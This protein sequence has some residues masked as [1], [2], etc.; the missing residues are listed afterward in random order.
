M[1][2]RPAGVVA[3]AVAVL[4]QQGLSVAPAA[5]GAPIPKDPTTVGQAAS[6]GYKVNTPAP[7]GLLPRRGHAQDS[8]LDG[9]GLQADRIGADVLD[10][11]VT[12][13]PKLGVMPSLDV[14]S[15][16]KGLPLA[17]P[18]LGS[19]LPSQAD[20]EG[21]LARATGVVDSLAG[22]LR[23]VGQGIYAAN[24]A[25]RTAGTAPPDF[26]VSASAGPTLNPGNT[27]TFTLT[28]TPLN[29]E[30][31]PV[32]LSVVAGIT[33]IVPPS[34]VVLAPYGTT[35]FT[36]E[37]PG[38][39]GPGTYSATVEAA[40]DNG[41]VHSTSFS[42]TLTTTPA[43]F[44]LTASPNPI[45][46]PIGGSG[47]MSVGL[48]AVN[49]LNS[50][51]QLSVVPL[52]SQPVQP[53][54]TWNGLGPATDV[55]RPYSAQTLGFT[56]PAATN[57]GSFSYDIVAT[58]YNAA[59]VD[60]VLPVTVVVT[61]GPEF[62]LTVS[63]GP[64]FN[65]GTTGTFTASISPVNGENRPIVITPVP[66]ALALGDAIT[67]P[68]AVVTAPY[69]P[70]TF[71]IT[72]N[73]HVPVLLTGPYSVT[74]EAADP[75]GLTHS[76]GTSYNKTAL[77]ADFRLAANP[78]SLT[79]GQGRS[80]ATGVA[81]SGLNGMSADV[82][83]TVT[84]P[85]P[86]TT[87]PIVPAATWGNLAPAVD[88]AAP[89]AGQT[90]TFTVPA[91][92]A[93]GQY[94]YTV[95][96]TSANSASATQ[97][98][99]VALTV[100]TGTGPDFRL[101]MSAGPTF[102]PGTSGTFTATVTPVNGESSPIVLTPDQGPGVVT[103]PSVVLQAPYPPVTFT[104]AANASVP[105]GAYAE[106]VTGVDANG[107]PRRTTS[108]Y[109]LTT[110]P[111]SFGL[112]AS[113][114]T[115]TVSP[116]GS[117][118]LNV[119]IAPANGMGADVVLTATPASDNPAQAMPVPAFSTHLPATDVSSPY[120]AQ[121]LTFT[122]PPNV[123]GGTYHYT[124][125]GAS[126][127]ASPANRA[128]DVWVQ[129]ANSPDFS[130]SASAGPAINPGSTGTFSV[131]V[132]PING[133]SA[134]VSLTPVQTGAAIT[135][136]AAVAQ[137]PYGVYQFTV[138][139]PAQATP[140]VYTVTVA[141]VDSQGRFHTVGTTYTV[142][143]N[144]ASFTLAANPATSSVQQG[145]SGGTTVSIVPANG[146]NGDIQLTVAPGSDSAAPI[147]PVA[148]WSNHAAAIDVSSPYA[149]QALTFTVPPLTNPGT[150]HFV[151]TASSA[152]SNP[153][154]RSLDVWVAVLPG[155]SPVPNLGPVSAEFQLTVTAGSTTQNFNLLLCVPT[156]IDAQ[157][158]DPTHPTTTVSLCPVPLGVS[159]LL[160]PP[161]GQPAQLYLSVSRI[162]GTPQFP[163]RFLASY[164][165]PG[166]NPMTVYF[167][168]DSGASVYPDNAVVGAA[169]DY[170]P[171]GS[172]A[173]IHTTM[174]WS[175][176]GPEGRILVGASSFGEADIYPIPAG[177]GTFALS[178]DNGKFSS[179]LANTNPLPPGPTPTVA[180][181]TAIPN[182]N[183]QGRALLTWTNIPQDFTFNLHAVVP[184]N[185]Q[186]NGFDFD[187]AQ[188]PSA[189]PAFGV[190][191][192]LLT[193]NALSGR[194]TQSP[195]GASFSEN[196]QL[197]RD[198]NQN[199]TGVDVQ[200]T[201]GTFS[202]ILLS[203]YQGGAPAAVLELVNVSG[204]ASE[205]TVN[206]QGSDSSGAIGVTL[207]A[208]NAPQF[209]GIGSYYASLA[210]GSV[211]STVQGSLT[212]TQA[213]A[214]PSIPVGIPAGVQAA[215][216]ATGV[217]PS[218]KI[219]MQVPTSGD[220]GSGAGAA[221][222]FEISG[223]T[224][225]S[226]TASHI[227]L[228]G[229][230]DPSHRAAVVMN[231]LGMQWDFKVTP[232]G[233]TTSNLGVDLSDAN[234]PFSPAEFKEI[235]V[236]TNVTG[237]YQPEYTFVLQR[238][239]SDTTGRIAPAGA[240]VTVSDPPATFD[241]T[242]HASVTNAN[243][244]CY[245]NL[246][247]SGSDPSAAPGSVSLS[248]NGQSV[249][250]L[251]EFV[252]GSWAVY[253]SGQ[254]ATG[255]SMDAAA[256]EVHQGIGPNP[257][258]QLVLSAPALGTQGTGK[259]TLTGFATTTD[260]WLT[261]L[262]DSAGS[263]AGA[264]MNG[265]NSENNPYWRL[266][267]DLIVG[268]NIVYAFNLA[269][270]AYA[271]GDQGSAA[272]AVA[273]NVPQ[274]FGLTVNRPTPS[275]VY[276]QSSNPA[277]APAEK[278]VIIGV[279][280]VGANTVEQLTIASFD[281]STA[282]Q[283]TG[284][285]SL[286]SSQLE[287]SASV[288]N[289][290]VNSNPGEIISATILSGGYPQ[291]SILL[292]GP[293]A[294]LSLAPGAG[295]LGTVRWQPMPPTFNLG[296]KAASSGSLHEPQANASLQV[297]IS[298]AQAM[299]SSFFTISQPQQNA[300]VVINGTG[301]NQTA[302]LSFSRSDGPSPVYDFQAN[303]TLPSGFN[304]MQVYAIFGPNDPYNSIYT[305][306]RDG[307]L[308]Q[309][310]DSNGTDIE[311][312]P[313]PSQNDYY[314]EAHRAGSNNRFFSSDTVGG[315]AVSVAQYYQPAN[316]TSDTFCIPFGDGVHY[317]CTAF[318]LWGIPQSADLTATLEQGKSSMSY[319]GTGPLDIMVQS[320]VPS[321][322]AILDSPG[323]PNGWSIS[324]DI[325]G[326]SGVK[327]SIYAGGAGM[328]YIYLSAW[329]IPLSFTTPQSCTMPA[330]QFVGQTLASATATVTPN[331]SYLVS[332][333]LT[334]EP[335]VTWVKIAPVSTENCGWMGLEGVRVD[336]GTP[337]PY[338]GFF[339]ANLSLETSYNE[340]STLNWSWSGPLFTG[341][342]DS[343]SWYDSI[344]G[345]IHDISSWVWEA[346]RNDTSNR[347]SYTG[348]PGCGAGLQQ[349]NKDETQ[350][351]PSTTPFPPSFTQIN[352]GM[353]VCGGHVAYY[354]LNPEGLLFEHCDD[355]GGSCA[356]P[357]S[358]FST[359]GIGPYQSDWLLALA[360]KKEY[361]ADAGAMWNLSP[362]N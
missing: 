304:N 97:Q 175:L 65:Q 186:P 85:A 321:L 178:Y 157:S 24:Q 189:N 201:P 76:A 199:V 87:Q 310:F 341:D 90:L 52:N 193:N 89:Y 237:S 184:A 95:T 320:L 92:T 348:T 360:M 191:L 297:D 171:L 273:T 140:G 271:G 136:P 257:A 51:I 356:D 173:A 317:P 101:T 53:V 266:N 276:V 313:A 54:A 206:L 225:D 122:A 255:C 33:P 81:I 10:P 18:N 228:V 236:T 133:E 134:P 179:Q 277:P 130:L 318:N 197:T 60:Q 242:V 8:I 126:S 289:S 312:D 68:S 239:G 159:S 161:L 62:N 28:V 196:V 284:D 358:R 230:V 256:L 82:Q 244:T 120:P 229:Q 56:V 303:G 301:A 63:A 300:N 152:G 323:L 333:Q 35:T 190:Q 39:E 164:T 44:S 121:A 332:A 66:A 3:V 75:T 212:L 188:A 144:A 67:P 330:I 247:V 155:P 15:L 218:F 107:N 20:L 99:D 314:L 262:R 259:L 61:Q 344:G 100:G 351:F 254:G 6:G 251:N 98:I 74:V 163:A 123:V 119:G 34:T 169:S 86:T 17:L 211:T 272:T 243:G 57:S 326:A 72:S 30:S 128:L 353:I 292:A 147:E 177:S 104:V 291:F 335:G 4:L 22:T 114:S 342:S 165:V 166:V 88:V 32:S 246:E 80:G 220:S 113:P 302:N 331:L 222:S 287:A 19:L 154:T 325:D 213:G 111:A 232:H 324:V 11:L 116:G 334:V 93:I 345:T 59:H 361:T 160:V 83:L 208:T 138:S 270:G 131:G 142:T 13:L 282:V 124:V 14:T 41:N 227:L 71:T 299:P 198:Q 158:T 5:A 307:S 187:G 288:Q 216:T 294:D 9:R 172:S 245:E 275:S 146:M 340:I 55:G 115:V 315:G 27:A 7:P 280:I 135:P 231:A 264:V 204:S 42:Y 36:M 102:N 263:P 249:Q 151:V 110:T 354:Q 327:G 279:G 223:S 170:N 238:A 94:H 25:S 1:L 224:S 149:A 117:A 2:R 26:T 329:N 43:D 112:S 215:L 181:S 286:S 319:T 180:V 70:V 108:S 296:L 129:V 298:G 260:L 40:D 31:S 69:S 278:L 283:L 240:T 176:S 109:T 143:A 77:A 357:S 200:G 79:V 182:T 362:G 58:S 350:W 274:V 336:G 309:G 349:V 21:V 48:N 281:T 185:G 46:L 267:V 217:D 73:A 49:G 346:Q 328:P 141:G 47:S 293:S 37:P 12:K 162:P 258:G 50:D 221:T 194:Y 127:N 91:N 233:T 347:W 269:T 106:A 195:L 253:I 139:V 168:A 268:S 16:L 156:P 118:S 78:A 183:G 311:I 210:G 234:T 338:S 84:P 203:S 192:D 219:Q 295:S 235:Y 209:I 202:T 137:A 343:F 241:M 29:G 45:T 248:F 339:T 64:T 265:D 174:G 226:V 252:T 167:G 316:L 290:N 103:P 38:L 359:A 23:G 214:N 105:P 308:A 145:A 207:S 132:S 337:G 285:L 96:G 205:V 261:L 305:V 250:I 150:Y 322:G 352:D 148:L 153:A 355:F 125:T 306:Y